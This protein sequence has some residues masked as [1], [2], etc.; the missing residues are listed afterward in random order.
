[1]AMIW[2]L[3]KSR[4]KDG[5][6]FFPRCLFHPG[7]AWNGPI[8]GWLCQCHIGVQCSIVHVLPSNSNAIAAA[9][10]EGEDMLGH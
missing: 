2:L 7:M 6:F 1:M 5:V 10:S 3:Q 4:E 9:G 8:K